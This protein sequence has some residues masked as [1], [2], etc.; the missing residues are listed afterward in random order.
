MRR[1]V[2]TSTCL[3]ALLSLGCPD[4]HSTGLADSG[5]DGGSPP[6]TSADVRG[7]AGAYVPSCE[8]MR[9]ALD[10]CEAPCR[11]V[12][13]AFWDGAACVPYCEECVGEECGVYTT[14][15]ACVSDHASC[16]ATLCESTSG[17]WFNVP[18][19]CGHHVCGVP[20]AATCFA[21]TR[22][23]NCGTGRNFQ[24]GVG[25]VVDVSCPAVDPVVDEEASCLAT[26]GRWDVSTCGHYDCGRP[27]LLECVSPGC[28]CGP[29]RSFDGALGCI[30]RGACQARRLDEVCGGE[31][32]CAEGVCCSV[33]GA[34]AEQRCTAPMCE[35]P[36]GVC[37]PAR[38]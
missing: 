9:A 1:A 15:E 17:D 26:G 19:L 22:G 33:G 30:L 10:P 27:S 37:G 28:D 5:L 29:F 14:L 25:C 31:S 35:S 36:A 16:D 20:N 6:D 13:G 8:P 3:V 2:P 23:C 18:S 34:S 38:P 12:R 7:D 4:T 11:A 24:A 32:A 21:P